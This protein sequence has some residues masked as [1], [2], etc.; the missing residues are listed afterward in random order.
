MMSEPSAIPTRLTPIRL[1]APSGRAVLGRVPVPITTLVGREQDVAAVSALLRDPAVRLVTMTGP[2]GVGKTRLALQVAVELAA[3]FADGIAF[4]DLASIRDPAIVAPT[5]AHDLGLRTRGDQPA[6]EM[7]ESFLHTREAL[8]VLDNFEQ[9]VAAGPQITDLLRACP[10]LKVLV[11]SRTLLHVSGER[12]VPVS[13]LSLPRRS[14]GSGQLAAQAASSQSPAQV[15]FG[16]EA[17][18]LFVERTREVRPGFA[19]TEAN[20]AAVAEICRRLD[21]LP[22]AIELAAAR[23]QLFT[24]QALLERLDPRLPQL[25]HG[26][27]DLPARLQ[28][29]RDAIAWSYDLL[30]SPEQEV[31]RCL[32]VFQGGCTLEAAEAVCESPTVPDV[33]GAVESLVEQSL[34]R[35]IDTNG[36]DAPRLVM[37]ETVREFA[38]ELL[39]ESGQQEVR[40]RHA[41]YYLDLATRAGQTFWGDEP[42]DLRRLIFPE[43]G[44]LRGALDWAFEHGEVEMALRLAATM[45]DPHSITGS[46]AR[47]QRIWLQRALALP[48]GELASRVRALT[49]GAALAVVEGKLAEGLALTQ[50]ALSLARQHDDLFGIAEASRIRGSLLTHAGDLEGA[51]RALRDS[52]SGFRAL[53]AQGRIGWTLFTLAA[54]EGYEA[55]DEGGVESDLANVTAACEE[56]LT[57]FREIDHGRGRSAVLICYAA[58]AHKRRDLPKALAI[59]REGLLA[60]WAERELVFHYLEVIADIAGRV[61]QAEAAARL[62]GASAEQRELSGRPLEPAYYEEY[63]RDVAFARQALG[64]EAFAASFAAGRALTTDLSVAEA[65]AFTLTESAP[66]AINL[67]PRASEILPL[68]AAGMSNP[69]IAGALFLSVR[70]VERHVASLF[71]IL[72]VHSRS[73][74][75]EAAVGAGLLTESAISEGAIPTASTQP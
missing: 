10:D 17:V 4:V 56:A 40:R 72:G 54:S 58:N 74:A 14:G 49:H 44:N 23:G 5:I 66:S 55:V 59:A 30:T 25:T 6:Q 62:Y 21:G 3:D 22:L 15:L 28:T 71:Q 20:A 73:A 26:P 67:P 47:E 24:P 36:T 65:L 18:R 61:G 13:P 8:L 46:N 38:N 51:H 70:T 48:G 31:F 39:I 35:V 68:L 53:N 1:P 29:M 41:A 52:L 9:I 57:I 27:R 45:F 69:E 33:I 2:G 75:I 64:A 7:L 42:G 16:S 19:L 63:E 34:V 60:D 11:T 50:E 32:G 12:A 43:A 37:L